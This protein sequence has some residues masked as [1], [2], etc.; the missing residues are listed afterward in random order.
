MRERAPRTLDFTLKVLR[1]AKV[2]ELRMLTNAK[3]ACGLSRQE[4][5]PPPPSRVLVKS[6]NMSCNCML[7][8]LGYMQ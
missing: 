3:L 2:I 6:R 5:V 4:F 8:Y 7:E 1:T